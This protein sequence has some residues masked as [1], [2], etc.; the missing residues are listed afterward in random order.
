MFPL[1]S[2]PPLT[3]A[4]PAQGP[5]FLRLWVMVAGGAPWAGF[6]GMGGPG[7]ANSGALVFPLFS[8]PPLTTV[9]SSPGAALFAVM[10]Y[11]CWRGSLGW[12]YRYG[13]AWRCEQR[14]PCVPSVLHATPHH[15]P[16]QPRG[17]GWFALGF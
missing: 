14:G 10:G 7:A 9:P 12:F 15:S 11:G 5:R 16:L 13:G 8:T 6:T 1:F 3:T 17:Q 2:T 4:P